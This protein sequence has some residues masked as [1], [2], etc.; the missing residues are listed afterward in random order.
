MIFTALDFY[1]KQKETTG[2][3]LT[4][5]TS[6]GQGPREVT[7]ESSAMKRYL[8]EQGIP[9][10]QIIEEDRSTSTY[11]NMMFSKE[12]IYAIDPEAKIAFSTSNYHVFRSGI[13]G[14]CCEP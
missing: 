3:E 2:K 12:K 8:I 9:E 13:R 1:R 5:V 10:T 14:T 4:F 11:E 7:T 6:G